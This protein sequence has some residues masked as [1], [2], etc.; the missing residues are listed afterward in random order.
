MSW[1]GAL[2]VASF[3]LTRESNQPIID[4]VPFQ[5]QYKWTTALIFFSSMLVS[6][7]ELVGKHHKILCYN[8]RFEVY[9]KLINTFLIIHSVIE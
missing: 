7:A 3:W 9:L 4:D 5:L 6:V 8:E 2:G 1:K